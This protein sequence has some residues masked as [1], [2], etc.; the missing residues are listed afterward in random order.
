MG[1]LINLKS[2][3]IQKRDR[4]MDEL[5]KS[6]RE[7]EYFL[8]SVVK[9]YYEIGEPNPVPNVIITARMMLEGNIDNYLL[10]Q[11]QDRGLML[12]TK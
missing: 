7:I 10:E 9:L 3:K 11:C 12:I 8:E 6:D 2:L 4:D 5:N 1:E